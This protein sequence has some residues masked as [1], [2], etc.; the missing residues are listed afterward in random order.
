VHPWKSTNSGG[1]VCIDGNQGEFERL[2]LLMG[3]KA[4]KLTTRK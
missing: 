1:L 4:T 2:A 3:K